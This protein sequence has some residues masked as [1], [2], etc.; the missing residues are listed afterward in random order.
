MNIQQR[1]EWFYRMRKHYGMS[2]LILWNGNTP[3]MMAA[4]H[5]GPR[6]AYACGQLPP[7]YP[8]P[9]IRYQDYHYWDDGVT[10]TIHLNPK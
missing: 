5:A 2:D 8:V 7:R 9:A 10:R 4:K 3:Y 6:M 1:H